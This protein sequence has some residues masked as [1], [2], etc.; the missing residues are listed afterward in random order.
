MAKYRINIPIKRLMDSILIPE[1][2]GG[3]KKDQL[4][5]PGLGL[6]ENPFF[7]ASKKKKKKKKK[8]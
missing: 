8:K 6:M 3:E 7:K 2:L 4:P 1:G 5:P